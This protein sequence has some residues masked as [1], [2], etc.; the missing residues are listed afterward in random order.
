M[1]GKRLEKMKIRRK[2]TSVKKKI[3]VCHRKWKM[4]DSKRK[5]AFAGTEKGFWLASQL[6]L[7]VI[8]GAAVSSL[9]KTEWLGF[10][11]GAALAVPVGILGTKLAGCL[12]RTVLKCS[13]QSLA[14]ALFDF[15]IL[16]S[17]SVE[18]SIG[19]EENAAVFVGI[20]MFA[21]T[22]L[23]S[24]S[25]WAFFVGKMRKGWMAALLLST[26]VMTGASVWFL[27]ADGFEDSYVSEYRK[28]DK[29]AK[30][31]PGFEEY[32]EPGIYTVETLEYSPYKEVEVKTETVDLRDFVRKGETWHE[33]YRDLFQTYGLGNAPVA[34]KVWYPAEAQSCPVIFMAHGNHSITEESYLGYAY[35]GEYLASH[36]Y[37]FVSVDENVLNERSGENDGRAVLLLENIKALQKWNEQEENPLYQKMD[38]DNIALAGHSRGGEMI[39]DAYLFNDCEAYPSNGMISFDYHFSI[40]ALLAVAP[41]VNQYRP[42][43]HEVELSDANYLVV[44]GAND[45]DISVFMGNQQYENIAFSGKGDYLKASLYITGANHGQFNSLWGKYD[46]EPPLSWWLNVGNL[47]PEEEQQYLLKIFARAFFDKTL[48][49]ECTYED[50]L[51]AASKYENYLQETLY[52]QQYEQSAFSLMADFEEDTDLTTATDGSSLL[53]DHMSMWTE[54]KITDSRDGEGERENHALRLKWKET[55]QAS[56]EITPEHPISL[57]GAALRFDV[58]NLLS[59]ETEKPLDFTVALT[60]ETG[61][62][63]SAVVG[64]YRT[65][66]P[67]FPVTLSKVQHLFGD[68]EEKYQF[69]T[70]SIPAE[71]FKGAETFDFTKVRSISLVFDVSDHGELWLDNI[72]TINSTS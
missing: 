6:F 16:V 41:S 47:I 12:F 36:G 37:V 62:R 39:A 56:Y 1:T 31:I 34:G 8:L 54:E 67:A 52:V 50:L 35:L 14:Y 24:K 42:A 58:C 2:I 17:L 55:K 5:A 3:K 57:E 40:K 18:C 63:V 7:C 59:E 66:Y 10:L 13:G 45:Q 46:M 72:G 25:L 19:A 60:D 38:Y 43:D 64:D 44:Q 69:Q 21:G 26:G 32:G 28:W 49:G 29:T 15:V 22:A 27:A 61:N 71:D 48:K 65:L 4:M 23:F 20:V 30:E 53:A 70:V 11:L 51:T 33:A 9:L 68:S